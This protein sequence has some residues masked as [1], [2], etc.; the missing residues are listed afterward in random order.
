MMNKENPPTTDRSLHGAISGT[1]TTYEEALRAL[2]GG[3]LFG[4]V[5]PVVGHPLDTVKTKMQADAKYQHMKVTHVIRDMWKVGRIRGFYKGFIPPLM[6]SAFYRS[7]QFSSYAATYSA[8]EHVPA[9]SEPIPYTGGLRISVLLGSC[10][11]AFARATIESPFEFI[12]V[13]TQLDSHWHIGDGSLRSMMSTKM[14][15]NIYH[16]YIPTLK[17]TILLLGSFFI[18]V[19]YSVRYLP[20]IINAPLAGPFFKVSV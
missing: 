3:A 10:A 8:C 14:I 1:G 19:D 12:K 7:V 18:M 15:A 17:R 4:M 5:S 16:G 9:L 2:I 13:R 11:A 20:D 6:A